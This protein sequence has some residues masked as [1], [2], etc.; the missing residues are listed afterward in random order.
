MNAEGL[1]KAVQDVPLLE[2]RNGTKRFGGLTAVGDVSFKVNE[3]EILGL[4]GPN[5]AGKSTL[6]NLLTGV[7]PLTSGD[8]LLS[9]NSIAA[10]PL[11]KRPSIGMSRTFQIVRLFNGMTVLENV[12][13]GYHPLLAD[14]LLRSLFGLGHTLRQEQ[15]SIDLA[16]EMLGFVGLAE[17]AHEEISHLPH[18]KQRLVEIA[19]A[20]AIEPRMLLVDEPAAGLN[21]Q[22]T[23]NLGR[24]LREL[25]ARGVTVLIVE[26]DIDFIMGL[27]DRIVVLDHGTKI[28]EGLPS[29][30]QTNE[31]VIEAYL[32]RRN[33]NAA[34]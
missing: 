10:M 1:A 26:H 12:L 20:L 34:G 28:A 21:S 22:E 15:R 11:Y 8:I 17:L 2:I 9:G 32:G 19:R 6:F 27:C 23:A 16:M 30:I 31:Q 14:G 24:M 18:G 7:A 5:G 33:K 3:G 4:I 29:A 25:N 13:M